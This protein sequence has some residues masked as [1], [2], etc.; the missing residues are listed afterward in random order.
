MK[1]KLLPF[2]GIVLLCC[3]GFG[4][5]L[6]NE[7][8]SGIQHIKPAV[9]IAATELY[10]EYNSNEKN[11]DSKYIDKVIEVSGIVSDDQKTDST[12]NISLK[13]G[14]MGGINCSLS[15]SDNKNISMP[16]VGTNLTLK[17]KCTGFLMDVELV[18]CVIIK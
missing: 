2:T 6:F 7:P 9:T 17:G 10:E 4:L 15:L 13:G 8:H 5:Y 12:I 3:I 1:K 14:T 16:A 18:D 11:A